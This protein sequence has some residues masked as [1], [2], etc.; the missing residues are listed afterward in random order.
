MPSRMMHL[1]VADRVASVLEISDRPRLLLGSIAPDGVQDKQH[2]HFKGS[3]YLHSDGAA[4]EYGRFLARYPDRLHD[5]Y[6]LGYLTHLV[7][8]DLLASLFYFSGIK[9]KLRAPGG[10]EALYEDY[11]TLNPWLV[12][13]AENPNLQGELAAAGSAP[14]LQELSS[15]AAWDA[16]D[17]ALDDF[18]DGPDVL[19]RPLTVMALDEWEAYIERATHRAIDICRP[20]AQGTRI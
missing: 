15:A 14:D 16:R 11:R 4:F 13:R 17:E 1:W 20:W 3:R 6:F 18:G 12:Q 9:A 10:Y 19:D 2:S 7:V 8:D 5:P